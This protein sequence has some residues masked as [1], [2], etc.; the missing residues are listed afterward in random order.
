MSSSSSSGP[1]PAA[2]GR[3]WP[4][5][6][7]RTIDAPRANVWAAI[8]KPGHLVDCHPY[9]AANPVTVWPGPESRDEVHYLNG[10]VFERRFRR[11]DD[12]SG[13]ELEIGR[14]GGPASYVT[15]ALEDAPSDRS[16]LCITVHPH[17]LQGWPG[18]VGA[19]PY[20]LWL[21]PRLEA[22]LDAVTRGV[23]WFVTRG[24][25]V[26]RDRFRPHPWFSAGANGRRPVRSSP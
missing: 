11:W 17:L 5:R 19:L 7:C 15:W 24:E 21:R 9:C 10:V 13:Y 12:G 22:Y 23:E 8:S 26:P 16:R 18:V 1:D 2:P 3:R 14:R 6:V 25:R 4:I 20:R